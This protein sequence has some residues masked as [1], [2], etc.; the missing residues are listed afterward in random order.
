MLLEVTGLT[1]PG[2]FTDIDLTVRAGEIV[3]LAGLVGAGRSEVAQA[4]FG[5]DPY[6]AGEV[7]VAGE[8]SPRATP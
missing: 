3:G 1:Q 6:A 8:P 7:R 5:V 4:V 2:L